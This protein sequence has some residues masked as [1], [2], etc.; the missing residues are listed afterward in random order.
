MIEPTARALV[1]GGAGFIGSNLVDLLVAEGWEV[2][3]VDDLSSGHADHLSAS[4][5]RGRVKLHTLDIREESVVG[6]AEHFHPHV[7]YHLAAQVSVPVSVLDPHRDADVNVLGTINVLTAAHRSGAERV[8]LAGSA[9]AYGSAVKLPARE[10]YARHPDSPYGAAKKAIEDYAHVFSV[11]HGLDFVVLAPAN[12]YGPR[13]DASG[14]G[15]VVAIFADA[16]TAG[17]QPTIF[18]DGTATRDF[19]FVDDVADAFLRAASRGSGRNLNIS[20]GVETSVGE[21][22]D[23]IARLARFRKSPRFNDRRPGDIDRSV[24]DPGAAE[25]SLGWKA[26]TPLEEGLAKTLEWFAK[27]S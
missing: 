11:R 8:V 23:S 10:T 14:E 16:V 5:Q 7:V 25:R 13:Q 24:L 1:T 6:V 17:K 26:W 15:G 9:A 20:S 18:G 21:L 19:V 3:V 4:R 12:V 22:Y 2:L 27:R